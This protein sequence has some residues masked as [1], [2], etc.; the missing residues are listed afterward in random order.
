MKRAFV[1]ST[2]AAFLALAM[3]SATAWSQESVPDDNRTASIRGSV[4]Y[5]DG[6]PV[7]QYPVEYRSAE[8]LE[9]RNNVRTDKDGNY[10]IAGLSPGE[11]LI[12]F[13]HPSRL[14][15]DRNPAIESAP[16]L[17]PG[18]DA[19]DAPVSRRVTVAA[20]DA[21]V[22]IDFVLIDTGA[23]RVAA[24]TID[25]GGDTGGLPNAGTSSVP[26]A[27]EH[28]SLRLAVAIALA[29]AGALAAVY[30][31]LWASRRRA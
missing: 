2:A 29:A 19:R 13:F 10:I 9:Q 27:N 3:A 14:P 16:E 26:S 24:E 31:A 21:V 7:G 30:L 25:T 5:T 23:E 15:S 11:Y 8:K 20:G 18:L 17:A 22:G 6:R 28:T 4:T 1:L 12:G